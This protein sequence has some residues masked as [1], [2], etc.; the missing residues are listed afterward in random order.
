MTTYSQFRSNPYSLVLQVFA[1]LLGGVSLFILGVALW[2]FGYQLWYSGRIFPGV[3]MAGVDLSGLPVA[4]ASARLEQALT[5]PQSGKIVF[6]DGEKV[7]VAAP[8]ELGVGLDSAS[9]VQQAY[10]LGRSGGLFGSLEDQLQSWQ[11]GVDVSPVLLFHLRV[12]YD[13]LKMVAT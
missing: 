11:R 5:Y 10:R 9:S 13:Y 12:A 2:V 4:Q 8:A 7:W 3:S 6:R 1:A